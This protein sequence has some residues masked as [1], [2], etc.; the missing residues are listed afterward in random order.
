[1]NTG[2][3]TQ[4]LINHTSI[5]MRFGDHVDSPRTVISTGMCESSLFTA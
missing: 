2:T 3:S 5:D 1:L 4:G